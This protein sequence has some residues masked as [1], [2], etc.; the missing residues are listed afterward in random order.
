MPIGSVVDTT[1]LITW[2]AVSAAFIAWVFNA[3]LHARGPRR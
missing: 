2:I 3:W 1:L